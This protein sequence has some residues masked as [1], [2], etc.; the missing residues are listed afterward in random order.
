MLIASQRPAATHLAGF[1]TWQQLGR[2]VKRELGALSRPPSPVARLKL[3][4]CSSQSLN[5]RK[6]V[7]GP[8]EGARRGAWQLFILMCP[9]G[10]R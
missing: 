10:A 1:H 4:W 2:F 9:M 7:S 5:G 3:S 8:M 6:Q